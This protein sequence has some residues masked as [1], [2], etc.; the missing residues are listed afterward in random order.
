V[1]W[2][3]AI[4]YLAICLA[5]SG[6]AMAAPVIVGFSLPAGTPG[7][8][9][10]L[11][12][13]GFSGGGI[14]VRFWNGGAGVVAPISFI[15]SDTVM[16]VTVPNGIATGPI[17]IQQGTGTPFFTADDFLV[18][19]LGPYIS[20]FLPTFGAVNDTVVINGVHL[21]NT[22]SV[23]FNGTNTFE[24]NPSADGTVVS[25]RVPVGATSGFITVRTTFGTSNSPSAFTVV[26]PGPYLTDFFPSFGNGG[27]T[28]T[29]NGLHL[30]GVTNVTF[31][32][33]PGIIV[34]ATSD[35][36]IQVKAPS[37]VTTGPISVSTVLGN[38]ST[39]ANFFGTPTISSVTPLFGRMNTNVTILG[40]NFLGSTAV[41]FNGVASTNF[42]ILN[43]S[44][45]TTA[46]PIGATTGLIRVI[47]PGGSAF[48]ASNF[49]V[50][51]TIS[52]FSPGFGSAGTAITIKGANLNVGTPVV[53]FN[54]TQAAPPTGVTFGQ[55]VAQ[56]P[57][58]VLSGH[59]SV[60]TADGSDTSSALFYIPATITSFT[61]TN[62][63]SGS[64][65]RIVG[66]NF[67]NASKVS[68][69]G[70]AA[71]DFVVT[72][73]TSIGATVPTG[74]VTGPISV[75]TPAG[76]AVSGALFYG[77]PV[78]TG[79]SPSHGLPG[80]NV[81][82]NGINFLG[83]SARF[84]G[85][86]ASIVS[87]N[88]TQMVATVPANAQTGLIT[89]SGPAG[90]N[91]STEKFILDFNSDL[92]VSITNSPARL[93]VGSNL[94]YTVSIVNGGPFAAPN[95]VL[96][97]YLPANVTLRSASITAPWVLATNGNMLFASLASFGQ[98][99]SAVFTLIVTPE[100]SGY[101]TNTVFVGSNNSDPIPG[102]NTATSVV[103][104]DP[105]AL[106]SIGRAGDLVRVSWSASLTNY[107][108][109]YQNLFG[110]TV[111]WSLFTNAPTTSGD[112]RFITDT[113]NGS[114]RFYRLRK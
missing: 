13:S 47:T 105:P 93:T 90:T 41:S 95:A 10:Q 27:T 26:G 60:T 35:T 73:T 15:N 64:R 98:G 113:N 89:V 87:L 1:I 97:N 21:T 2:K 29:L 94:V 102:N 101:V 37:G 112:L 59:I 28:V 96:T 76:V 38:F 42:S 52:S 108:L 67:T 103:A 83:G 65:V 78:I 68:F 48:S 109:Q 88:N 12:G 17:S 8:K 23:L 58:G 36:T 53:K 54:G 61:P 25:T 55:L 110:P 11:T 100:V 86:N 80:T 63:A 20:G 9:I 44:N 32:G 114:G 72:N 16:T 92:R 39:V 81:T 46:V 19:G 43:N 79:F 62:S 45:V 84:N 106:L 69:N 40:T 75:T 31:N 51:P 99:S 50:R 82:I 49:V 91:T 56:V 18:I 71:A 85:I 104:V 57:A 24:F 33:R 34:T 66:Q 7:D 30:T 6:Q 22:L 74:V 14:T 111:Q 4:L 3:P 77:A 70:T 5:T 107:V